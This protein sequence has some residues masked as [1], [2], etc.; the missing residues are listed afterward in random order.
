MKMRREKKKRKKRKERWEM[1]NQS[2]FIC[3][4]KQ[5]QRDSCGQD[6]EAKALTT[7]LGKDGKAAQ[8]E[9]RTFPWMFTSH[10]FP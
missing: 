4:N 10:T 7:A 6:S 3:R 9:M 8:V 2:I 1:I 5:V